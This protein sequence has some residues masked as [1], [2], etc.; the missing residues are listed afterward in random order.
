DLSRALALFIELQNALAHRNRYGSHKHTLPHTFPFVKLH[1]LWKCS[2][3]MISPKRL[4][5]TLRYLLLIAVL[6]ALVVKPSHAQTG[7]CPN[8]AMIGHWQGAMGREGDDVSVAF[9]FLCVDAELQASFTSMPQRAMEYP[10]DSAKQIGNQVELVLGGDTYFSGKVD[11]SELTGTFKDEDGS[12][13]FRLKHVAEVQLPYTA[14]DVVFKNGDVSL[15]G[16]LYVP[17]GDGLHPAIVMLQG[18]GPETRWGANRFWAD[19]FG[20]RGI[21]TLIYD[22][23]GSGKS[24]GDWQTSDFNSLAGDALAGV[25]FLQHQGGIDPKKI[26]IH[27]HSQGAAIA[28]LIASQSKAVAFVLADAATGIPMWQTEVF[29]QQSSI[30]HSGLKGNDLASADQFI[31]R[32][33]QVERSGNGRDA[34]VRDYK[35]ALQ[36]GQTWTKEIEPPGENSY[37]WKFFPMI[38]NYNP[39]DYWRHV[40]VPVL[41][42]EAGNDE[43]VPVDSS[44][45][46]IQAA[47][48]EGLNADYTI[49]VFP[50]AP[51]ALVERPKAGERFSWPFITPGYAD[52]LASWVL[53]R[54]SGK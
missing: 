54:E 44:V 19:Y 45:A 1:Y 20:R 24:T 32:S 25:S 18:S 7:A 35:A 53:Y 11:D 9:D 46:A 36:S 13:T 42:V 41:I 12:G 14:T 5:S 27:G 10:F 40:N 2:N 51:H 48:R 4:G 43:R 30:R 29:S 15:S 3:V 39:A 16:S 34:L 52:L 37:F 23:R 31:E 6:M 38:A 50:N 33:V 26:G 8:S 49:I 22:K 21:A 17:R 28:P 47:L